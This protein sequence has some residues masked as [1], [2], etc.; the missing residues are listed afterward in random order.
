MAGSSVGAASVGVGSTSV[1]VATPVGARA[2]VDN[3]GR[4]KGRVLVA[5]AVAR[6]GGC[7]GWNG[8]VPVRPAAG[9]IVTPGS[10]GSVPVATLVTVTAGTT[11]GSVAVND[12]VGASAAAGVAAAWLATGVAV[13]N[14]AATAA[15]GAGKAP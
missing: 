12:R 11:A 4:I 15:G 1:T 13:A 3:A 5:I 8:A 2:G 14:A 6:A 7:A 9:A 10:T